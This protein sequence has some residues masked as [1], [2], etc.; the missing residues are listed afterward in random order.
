MDE[1]IDQIIGMDLDHA[2]IYL[3]SINMFFS[4]FQ[5]DDQTKIAQTFG[6]I[7]FDRANVTVKNGII[8]GYYL[9]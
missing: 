6:N 4:I 1:Q 9:G 8:T 7:R 2:E 3:D 5:I